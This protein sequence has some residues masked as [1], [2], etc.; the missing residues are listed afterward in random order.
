M[1]LRHIIKSQLFDEMFLED[2]EYNIY[3]QICYLIALQRYRSLYI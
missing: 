3:Y 1:T 2:F